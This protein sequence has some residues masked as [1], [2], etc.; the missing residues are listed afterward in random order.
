MEKHRKG[1][2]PQTLKEALVAGYMSMAELNLALAVEDEET[3]SDWLSYEASLS[4][5][6]KRG[7][8]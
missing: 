7:N 4:E 1:D 5:D 6:D 2:A 3:L 8:S